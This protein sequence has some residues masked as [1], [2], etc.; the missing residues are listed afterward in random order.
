MLLRVSKITI[1]KYLED[2]DIFMKF[3]TK[4]FCKRQ[5][6]EQSASDEAESSFISKLT[7]C[8]GFEYISRLEKMVQDTQ[9]SK[10]LSSGY[11]DQQLEGSR[12]KKS[13]EFGIQVLSTGTW[14]SMMLVNLNMPRDLSTTV[15]GFTEFYNEKF[16]GRKLSFFNCFEFSINFFNL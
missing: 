8:C 12:S 13:I 15:E 11:K 2:K 3:Y 16:S 9:V 6:N 5:L 7:E 10:D 1:F 4:H 14:P